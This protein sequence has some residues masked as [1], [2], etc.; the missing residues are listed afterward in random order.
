MTTK[1]EIAEANTILKNQGI[2]IHHKDEHGNWIKINVTTLTE[3]LKRAKYGDKTSVA[4][5]WNIRSM[6]SG[7]HDTRSVG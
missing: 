3:I 6:T 4:T 5:R 1:E 7:V 2:E